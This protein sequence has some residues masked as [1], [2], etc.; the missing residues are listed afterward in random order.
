M[1]GGKPVFVSVLIRMH[2]LNATI[3]APIIGPILV[4][5]VCA[6]HGVHTPLRV[7][8]VLIVPFVFCPQDAQKLKTTRAGVATFFCA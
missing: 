8:G 5:M 1:P 3:S 4:L 6:K 7:L 2:D